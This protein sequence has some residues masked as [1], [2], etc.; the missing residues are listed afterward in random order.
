MKAMLLRQFGARLELAEVPI[1]EAP[2]GYAL[3][4]VKA[5]G[6]CSTDLKI[7]AGGH[8]SSPK[9]QLPHIL[10]HEVSGV[11]AALGE[12]VTQVQPG[13]R[14][15]VSMYASCGECFFCR[16]GRDTLC[17]GLVDWTGFTKA[18]G[19]AEFVPIRQQNL[20]RLPDA[21]PFEHAAILGDAVATTLHAVR[22]RG[23]VT[24]GM[25]VV[26]LGTGGLGL[27]GVQVAKRLGAR[28]IAVD[29]SAEKLAMAEEFGADVLLTDSPDL[30]ERVRLACGGMGPDVVVE[31]TG[32]PAAQR[33]AAA[34]LRPAGRL[35]LCGYQNTGDFAMPSMDLVLSEKEVVGARACTAS[36]LAETVDWV[37]RGWIQPVVGRVLPL[38]QA[39]AALDDL[40]QGRTLGRV[41]LQVGSR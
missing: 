2:P 11:V 23:R 36:E 30:P 15:A 4:Q 20:V 22:D 40:R 16:Q 37:A 13:D 39:N 32:N 3:V 35:V 31:F 14:V 17:T 1:P 8:L 19:M 41:V 21:I 9:V 18:G 29:V 38:E 24:E 7:A 10:G 6:V 5:V 25:N 28:V 26:I 33:T 12:E 34:Y 27:H